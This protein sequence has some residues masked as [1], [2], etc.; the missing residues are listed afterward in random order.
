MSEK[1]YKTPRPGGAARIKEV[2]SERRSRKPS[3]TLLDILKRKPD[4]P[5]RDDKKV[6]KPVEPRDVEL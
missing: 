3:K 4:E 5:T 1:Q 6:A 2:W